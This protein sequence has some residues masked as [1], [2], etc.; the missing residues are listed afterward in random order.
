MGTSISRI[1]TPIARLRS[2]VAIPVGIILFFLFVAIFAPLVTPY[3]PTKTSLPEKNIPPFW[4]EGGSISHPLGTDPLG[5]D[6]WARLA[7]GARIS[8]LV[9]ISTLALG[10]ILGTAL[11]DQHH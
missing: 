4:Q 10:G 8:L 7:Y 11:V 3:S 5:R 9:A 1:G 6:I 2:G